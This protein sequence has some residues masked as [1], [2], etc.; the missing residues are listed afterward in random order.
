MKN[1]IASNQNYILTNIVEEEYL[2]NKYYYFVNNYTRAM[3][4]QL[5]YERNKYYIKDR[6]EYI[7]STSDYDST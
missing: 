2:P 3:I 1:N 5:E 7:L 6:N 4:T